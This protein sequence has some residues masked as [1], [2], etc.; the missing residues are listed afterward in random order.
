MVPGLGIRVDIAL[1]PQW[2]WLD[3]VEAFETLWLRGF[4]F[5]QSER[6]PAAQAQAE[7]RARCGGLQLFHARLPARQGPGGGIQSC[8]GFRPH[9]RA[10]N[11]HKYGRAPELR[12]ARVQHSPSQPS[13]LHAGDEWRQARNPSAVSVSTSWANGSQAVK[14]FIWAAAGPQ[15]P[16]DPRILCSNRNLMQDPQ[17]RQAESSSPSHGG[18]G[19]P[20]PPQGHGNGA[21]AGVP[22]LREPWTHVNFSLYGF[23]PLYLERELPGIRA[24]FWVGLPDVSSA[25]CRFRSL[26]RLLWA[27]IPEPWNFPA[28]HLK[29]VQSRLR[30]A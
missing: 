2:L 16:H 7:H 10:R 20:L 14:E 4:S 19:R 15:T 24:L 13:R 1:W 21:V 28:I 6:E 25:W 3:R 29:E 18:P 11:G 27:E 30:I 5:G 8:Q 22:E 12:P 26:V 9:D 23:L 17:T